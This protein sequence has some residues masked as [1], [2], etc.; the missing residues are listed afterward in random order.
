MNERMTGGGGL[1]GFG[2]LDPS[3]G[4]PGTGKVK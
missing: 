1:A 3:S 4:K 2:S